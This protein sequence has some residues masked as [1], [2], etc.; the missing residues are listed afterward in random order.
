MMGRESQ[1]NRTEDFASC[2]CD[3]NEDVSSPLNNSGFSLLRYYDLASG[4]EGRLICR[5][6]HSESSDQLAEE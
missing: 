5:E 1:G 6:R 4:I 3:P 2:T